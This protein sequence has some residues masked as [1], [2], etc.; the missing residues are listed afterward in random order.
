MFAAMSQV[1][2]FLTILFNDGSAI[3]QEFPTYE[4]CEIARIALV[5]KMNANKTIVAQGCLRQRADGK[6]SAQ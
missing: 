2:F 3:K 5:Q 1:T 6:S 4:A